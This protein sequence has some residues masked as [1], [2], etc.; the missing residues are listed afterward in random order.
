M[1]RKRR[2]VGQ[3][4]DGEACCE[5]RKRQQVVP[6]R[7]ADA[8]LARQRAELT[9]KLHEL[10][11]QQEKVE[12]QAVDG[13]PVEQL[14]VRAVELHLDP[15]H[16]V[17]R[18]G[19]KTRGHRFQV[20]RDHDVGIAQHRVRAIG[21]RGKKIRDR[22]TRRSSRSRAPSGRVGPIPKPRSRIRKSAATIRCRGRATPG[23][24][25]LLTRLCARARHSS[26]SR[27]RRTRAVYPERWPHCATAFW[28]RCRR[29]AAPRPFRRRRTARARRAMKPSSSVRKRSARSNQ[30]RRHSTRPMTSRG[31]AIEFHPCRAEAL[32][33]LRARSPERRS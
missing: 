29:I 27:P 18:C 5:R 15:M 10:R 6:P 32:R 21:H 30:G 13:L 8:K 3:A 26:R 17:E 19:I 14:G 11:R 9:D 1:H 7:L 28:R 33:A 12:A 2:I 23:R 24:S 16:A 25:L 22:R 20:V 31:G 4:L